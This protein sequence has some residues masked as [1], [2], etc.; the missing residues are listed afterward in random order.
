MGSSKSHCLKAN[1]AWILKANLGWILV[2]VEAWDY[3][4]KVVNFDTY[5]KKLLIIL[6]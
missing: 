6:V 1:L 4:L 5:P 2:E 3:V